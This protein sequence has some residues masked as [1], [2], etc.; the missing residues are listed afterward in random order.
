VRI[1]QVDPRDADAFAAWFGVGDAVDR[2]LRPGESQVSLG[3]RRAFALAALEPAHDLTVVSLVARERDRAV[4]VAELELPRHDNLHL[5]E[6]RV[7]VLPD[8][9]RRGVGSALLAEVERVAG[10]HG[11]TSVL[12]AA[13]EPP[14]LLGRSPGRAFAERHGYFQAQVEVRRDLPLP[15]DA[16]RAARLAAEC[17]EHAQGYAVRT[18]RDRYP[19]D[20]VDAMAVLKQAMSTDAPVGDVDWQEEKWDAARLRQRELVVAAQGRTFFAAGAV[21]E[22][23]GRLVAFTEVGIALDQPERAYQWETLVLAEHRGHRLGTLVKLACLRAIADASPA[24]RYVSTWNAEENAPMIR[25]NDALG[26]RANGA[27]SLWQRRLS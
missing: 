1:E 13:D 18:W 20:L 15:V 21:H 19:D 23:S 10:Q 27:L 2:D 25:V 17:A 5:A 12:V 4:G 26:A 16:H 7:A 3:E 11:R 6:A 9:R 24:T 22:G 8:A 14:A